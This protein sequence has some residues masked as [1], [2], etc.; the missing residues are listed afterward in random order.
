MGWGIC[1]EDKMSTIYK[2]LDHTAD[3]AIEVFSDTEEGLF[4]NVG[5]ALFDLM[6]YASRKRAPN[7]RVYKV[8]GENIEEAIFNWARE[9][10]SIFYI[11]KFVCHRLY[12]KKLSEYNFTKYSVEIEVFGE[13]YDPSIHQ[14]KLELKAITRHKFFVKR[15]GSIWVANMIIDV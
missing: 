6:V 1:D 11:E 10:I 3:L 4:E 2:I 14:A 7:K 9:V 8:E 5:Y 13:L 12:T 15:K